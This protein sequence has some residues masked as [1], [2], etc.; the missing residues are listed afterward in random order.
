MTEPAAPPLERPQ[1]PRIRLPRMPRWMKG[2]LIAAAVGG[3]GLGV[4][5]GITFG[6]HRQPS[7][8][9][10]PTL[11]VGERIVTNRLST[12]P[13]RGVVVVFRYPEHP[14][15][16]FVKR[17]VGL[18]GDVVAVTNGEVSINGWKVPRCIV[19]QTAFAEE[20]AI[21][22]S[23]IKHEGMLAVEYL[24]A[25]SYLVF[26]EKASFGSPNDE[27]RWSVAPGQYF[28]LGDNRNN[29]HDSRMWFG[30]AGG[31][32]P[33]ANTQGRVRGHD[34]PE[35]PRNAQGAASLVPALAACLAKRPAQT[36]PPPPK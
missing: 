20:G 6:M 13:E 14:A 23:G 19:G 2:L 34:L 5:A 1:P 18:P 32:V 21:G 22:D 7:G 17:I 36:T 10:W 25:A 9:M 12:D 8:S 33:F 28:V 3:T 31:G 4:A 27:S 15:Q 11:Q 30:G 29:S 35:M 26:D 24:G 16:S